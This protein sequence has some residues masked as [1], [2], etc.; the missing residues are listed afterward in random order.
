MFQEERPRPVQGPACPGRR[1]RPFARCM[2]LFLRDKPGPAGRG[3]LAPSVSSG[4]PRQAAPTPPFLFLLQLQGLP[5]PGCRPGCSQMEPVPR[6]LQSGGRS[7]RPGHAMALRPWLWSLRLSPAQRPA[8]F[9]SRGS[10]IPGHPSIPP[11]SGGV[12]TGRPGRA[13][14]GEREGLGSRSLG[15]AGGGGNPRSPAVGASNSLCA[16]RVL[17]GSRRLSW[18]Q[19][20]LNVFPPVFLS[21]KPMGAPGRWRRS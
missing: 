6:S 17:S 12:G 15:V 4:R 20:D 7:A 1:S 2:C 18:A 13:L 5:R 9:T 21:Q 3:S 16:T 10:V 19:M 11:R 8:R 14:Q